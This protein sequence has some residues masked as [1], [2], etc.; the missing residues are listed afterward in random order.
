M[1]FRIASLKETAAKALRGCADEWRHGA[2]VHLRYSG[3]ALAF[4]APANLPPPAYGESA[5][6]IELRKI[7]FSDG[8]L[9]EAIERFAKAT[10][11][12]MPAGKIAECRVESKAG[13]ALIVRVYNVADG[14]EHTVRFDQATVAAALIRFCIDKKIPIPKTAEKSVEAHGQT[15]SLILRLGGTP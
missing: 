9:S 3:M 8:E 5:V 13:L 11:Y 10:R 12:P 14:S 4:R 6:P 1:T 2:R 15:L 7:T